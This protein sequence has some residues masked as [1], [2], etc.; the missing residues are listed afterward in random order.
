MVQLWVNLPAKDKAVPAGYQTIQAADIPTIAFPD[1]SGSLRVIAGD[2]EGQHG[3]A[4]IFSPLNVWDGKLEEGADI[5]LSLPA[6]HNAAI[7]SL[8]GKL[9]V[10]GAEEVGSAQF[11]LLDREGTQVTLQAPKASSFL[12]LTGAPLNEPIA[13]YGPF[14]MNTR[15]E[16]RQAIEDFNSG[17]F[18]AISA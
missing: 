6:G 11:A 5:T 2:Y 12:V 7:I 9:I 10:N 3:P 1:N 18:G 4:R 17:R 14:V 13:G 8:E 16:I 15:E